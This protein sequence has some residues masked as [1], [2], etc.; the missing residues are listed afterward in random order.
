MSLNYLYVSTS[1][2]MFQRAIWDKLP[3]CIFE[4]F[5]IAQLSNLRKTPKKLGYKSKCPVCH[6][7]QK[8]DI[9]TRQLQ[10]FYG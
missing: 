8:F 2:H 10:R 7:K 3:E 4:N 1:N 6:L 5:E 9:Y